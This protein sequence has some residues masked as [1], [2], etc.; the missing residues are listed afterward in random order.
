MPGNF[1]FPNH[2]VQRHLAATDGSI[3]T[4]CAELTAF[5]CQEPLLAWIVSDSLCP[6]LVNWSS[7]A[8]FAFLQQTRLR[9]ETSCFTW[10]TAEQ[11]YHS[12]CKHLNPAMPSHGQLYAKFC[13]YNTS[14]TFLNLCNTNETTL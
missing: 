9:T 12:F 4:G 7:S 8:R 10:W 11:N 14:I 6:K 2:F 5:I 1:C 13:E 3:S